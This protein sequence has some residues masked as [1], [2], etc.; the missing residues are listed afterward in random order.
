MFRKELLGRSKTELW[1]KENLWFSKKRRKNLVAVTLNGVDL[2]PERLLALE[3]G[4]L[5]ADH[6]GRFGYWDDVTTGGLKT[7]ILDQL[8][9][10]SKK[11]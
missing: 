7:K 2:K 6:K 4:K 3:D 11:L 8:R 10:R 5:F 1:L 9:N